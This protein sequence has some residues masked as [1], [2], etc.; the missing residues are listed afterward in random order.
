MCGA[1]Y[2]TGTAVLFDTSIWHTS[3]P[4]TSGRDR[5]GVVI[6]YRSSETR[7]PVRYIDIMHA[8]TYSIDYG[9]SSII[10]II[11]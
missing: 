10:I 2:K 8:S 5:R 4:N 6:G 9:P 1:H 3:L 11:S 7:A